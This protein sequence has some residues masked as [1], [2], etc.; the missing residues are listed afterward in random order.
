MRKGDF[1]LKVKMRY[2]ALQ[3]PRMNRKQVDA[4]INRALGRKS[5]W[6]WSDPRF[7]PM[8]T[9][10]SGIL[11]LLLIK[12]CSF[13]DIKISNKDVKIALRELC[14]DFLPVCKKRGWTDRAIDFFDKAKS[15]EQ[16]ILFDQELQKEMYTYFASNLTD[17][18]V[19]Q[20]LKNEAFVMKYLANP[21]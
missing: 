10:L 11:Y 13:Y 18:W 4:M 16:K 15:S 2:I 14:A 5:D 17:T 9:Y 20:M 6:H 3:P 12:N 21:C 1:V 7:N 19:K 8:R